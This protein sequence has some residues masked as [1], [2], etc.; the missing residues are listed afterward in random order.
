MLH[1]GKKNTGIAKG[2][3]DMHPS[4]TI[5]SL[6]E[7]ISGHTYQVGWIRADVPIQEKEILRILSNESE[8]VMFRKESTGTVV[9]ANHAAAEFVAVSE[10]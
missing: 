8:Y 6:A 2:G 10:I 7:V 3:L 9:I 5:I 1:L 4:N